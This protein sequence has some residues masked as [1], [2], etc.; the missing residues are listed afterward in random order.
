MLGAVAAGIVV[1]GTIGVTA[2]VTGET[3]SPVDRLI[4]GV[5]A[6][7]VVAATVV[8]IKECD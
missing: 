5:A 7:D 8:A 2:S 3:F 6:L 1:D 4:V